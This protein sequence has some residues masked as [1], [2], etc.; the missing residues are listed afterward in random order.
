MNEGVVKLSTATTVP[1]PYE[2][3]LSGLS[4]PAR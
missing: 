3:Y 2:V 4:V 1:A